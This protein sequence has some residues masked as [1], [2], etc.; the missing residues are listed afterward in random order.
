MGTHVPRSP[1]QQSFYDAREL[2]PA[3]PTQLHERRPLVEQA[4]LEKSGFALCVTSTA[5]PNGVA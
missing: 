4:W 3:S 1:A 5:G 2:D